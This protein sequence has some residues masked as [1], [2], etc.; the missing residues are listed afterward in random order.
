MREGP[1]ETTKEAH[2]THDT[3]MMR[4]WSELK[5]QAGSALLFFRLG[6]FY[7]LFGDDAKQA[8]PLMNVVLTSRNAKDANAIPLCGV[9]LSQFE[10]Y[11]SKVL[12]AGWKVALAEQT[13]E[14]KPGKSLVRRE[15]VQ[16]LTPGMR[17][18]PHE[19]R[20]HYIGALSMAGSSAQSDQWILAAA[21]VGTGDLRFFKGNQLSEVA[22]L[23]ERLP[24]ED[25]R[26]F[27]PLNVSFASRHSESIHLITASEAEAHILQGLNL[28]S[29]ADAPTQNK[30]EI[31]VLGSLLKVISD[32]HPREKLRFRAMGSDAS[33]VLM[34]AATRKNLNLFEPAGKSV[35]DFIN[36]T[37][38]AFGRRE[39]KRLLAEPTQNQSVISER[40]S[41]IHFFKSNSFIRKKFRERLRLALD[42]HRLLRG[43][44]QAKQIF[45]FQESLR[46]ALEAIQV[47]AGHHKS[48]QEALKSA[49]LLAPLSEK[50]QST[51]QWSD[52]EDHGWIKAGVLKDLDE[53]RQLQL[54]ANTV[55][56]QLEEK[57]RAETQISTLKIKF[58]QVFGYVFEVTAAHKDK[59]PSSAR[60]IQTLANAERFKTDELQSIEEKLLSLESRIR[61]AESAE[62]RRLG[63]QIES[64]ATS[65]EELVRVLAEL[66]SAQSLAEVSA[67]NHWT[68]PTT[69][70]DETS[71][72]EIEEGVHPLTHPFVPLSFRLDA[73]EQSLILLTGPNMAGKSTLM[74]VSALCALLHQIGSDIP[75]QKLESSL[76]DR[77]M[78]RMGAQDDLVSGQSTF[79]VEMKEVSQMIQG[80][81][82]KSFLLFDEIGRGTSTFDGMALAWAITEAVH[83]LKVLGIVAT[84]Y[85]E[86]AALENQ[87]RRLKAYHL[88]V[89]ELKGQ[90]LFTR[91]LLPGPA[92]RSY[93]IQVARLAQLPEGILRRAQERLQSLEESPKAKSQQ[94]KLFQFPSQSDR[95]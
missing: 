27:Q 2:S 17:F 20:P 75:A 4:Q 78:C 12:D 61:E 29:M 93:G 6:D 24:I 33:A 45:R 43:K 62:I 35:F 1:A 65:I 71:I 48:I 94:L 64:Q 40:Q 11:V 76:F 90:L 77:I 70:H 73:R 52:Q 89:E 55:L 53:L 87:C 68:T 51:L 83:D 84:H 59:V 38:T 63:D 47:L 36:H 25:L 3:P 18:L 72:F 31:Q 13:E 58:H 82:S 9:P 66:D 10:H 7:E 74:R 88:G 28:V 56:A 95:S 91:R 37:T 85:L 44:L 46:A 22:E 67:I 14:P 34:S 80:A 60:R 86:M 15:I 19:E 16:W 8:A 69:R 92:S 54:N 79:F 81:S 41:L 42:F 50:L 23:I 21:D 26:S 5:S 32:A 49:E 39:L 57:M 30:M